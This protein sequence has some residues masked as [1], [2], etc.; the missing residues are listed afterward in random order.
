MNGGSRSL[1]LIL[2]KQ[3]K[4]TKHTEKRLYSAVSD[5]KTDKKSTIESLEY[6]RH[7]TERIAL[8]LSLNR[9]ILA[10]R[11]EKMMM[12]GTYIEEQNEKVVGANFCRQRICP[13]CQRRRSLD[14][15]ANTREIVNYLTEKD[16]RKFLH[17]VLTVPNVGLCDLDDTITRM[18]KAS[19]AMF[20]DKQLCRKFKGVMR[21]L[22]VSYNK[23]VGYI[24]GD[25]DGGLRIIGNAFHPHLHCLVAVGKS[26]GSGKNYIRQDKLLELWR[27]YYG[28]D[29]ISQLHIAAVKDDGAVSEVAKYCVKPLDLDL[30]DYE[31]CCV[32]EAIFGALHGRRLIQLYGDFQDA[33]RALKIEMEADR[34]LKADEGFRIERYYYNLNKG[35]YELHGVSFAS[36][37]T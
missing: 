17:L 9:S 31:L 22:E 16:G 28:C 34:Q 27:S 7:Q 10:E 21:C 35:C 36:K 32:V 26:Y 6:Y 8:S 15:A 4:M 5:K 1:I 13:M 20:K 3:R 25:I 11:A 2:K 29:K 30:S 12:C 19:S 24:D 37:E 33:A 14:V 18:Y 23:K